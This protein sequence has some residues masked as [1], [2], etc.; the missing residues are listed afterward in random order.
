MPLPVSAAPAGEVQA[1]PL[2]HEVAKPVSGPDGNVWS[3]DTTN[4]RLMRI[5]PTGGVTYV[6][7]PDPGTGLA[8]LAAGSDGNL[9]T[10]AKG[11]HRLIRVTPEGQVTTFALTPFGG[12]EFMDIA[13]GPDG[14]LW[15]G[16]TDTAVSPDANYFFRVSTSATN[17][18]FFNASTGWFITDMTS[19]TSGVYFA[20]NT[21]ADIGRIQSDGTL[22]TMP[23]T[24]IAFGIAEGPDRRVW[25][26]PA[27]A[28]NLEAWTPGAGSTTS[29][30]TDGGSPADEVVTGADG[31]LW[32]TTSPGGTR[33]IARM[34][35][36][37]GSRAA[38][39][40]GLPAGGLVM[41]MTAAS[42]GSVWATF[43]LGGTPSIARIGTGVDRLARATL[44]GSGLAGSEHRCA[45]AVEATG[46]GAVRAQAWSWFADGAKIAGAD[47]AVYVP[48]GDLTGKALTCRASLTF[49]VALTQAGFTSSAVTVRAATPTPANGGS[50][51]GAAPKRLKASWARKGSKVTA[52][53]RAV[54]GAPR[55]VIRAT[56]KGSPARTGTC[57]VRTVKRARTVTCRITLPKGRWTVAA[58][59]RRGATPVARAT[60]AYRMG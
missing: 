27:F 56:R 60:R 50:S 5:T 34:S 18:E 1:F 33:T 45:V 42:D 6:T 43:S 54:S 7:V 53:F 25:V 57:T 11:V 22:S 14:N 8:G 28:A 51:S 9:W 55:N 52:T 37:G 3:I 17:G 20:H 41:G 12:S 29:Y 35:A 59:A 48:A 36:T 31:N 32:Y 40:A 16:M 46:L 30:P 24:P 2:S 4:A 38:Y 26:T 19:A 39:T 44:D 21:G 49:E 47:T 23:G 15:V 58:E 13:A 10:L